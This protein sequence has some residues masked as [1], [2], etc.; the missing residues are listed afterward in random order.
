MHIVRSHAAPARLVR[1]VLSELPE[2]FARP[3]ANA[4]YAQK[5]VTAPIFVAR[6]DGH[7]VGFAYLESHN[8]STF[9]IYCMAVRPGQHR[10]GVGVR[11]IAAVE[12]FARENGAEF[13]TVKTLGPSHPD[14]NYAKTRAFYASAGFVP[15]EE[16]DTLWGARTPCLLMV[17]PIAV[18]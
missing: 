5:A 3:D 13:L 4:H 17:K 2:W 18:H 14:P 6:D 15:L 1:E 11:L 8:A 7:D 9:E 10:Q 12:Q 16:F